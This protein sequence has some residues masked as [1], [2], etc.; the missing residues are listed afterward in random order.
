MVYI[1]VI[2]VLAIIIGIFCIDKK[3][4]NSVI[5]KVAKIENETLMWNNKDLKKK[6][7]EEKIFLSNFSNIQFQENGI[8]LEKLEKYHKVDK[9]LFLDYDKIMKVEKVYD[10][11]KY[12]LNNGV[13]TYDNYYLDIYYLE[14][15]MQNKERICIEKTKDVS[16]VDPA[17]KIKYNTYLSVLEEK[18]NEVSEN[19]LLV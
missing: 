3:Y 9:K 18:I 10:G 17:E 5:N 14:D 2:T 8:E 12:L 1:I 15:N 16:K 13:T 6:L 19:Q 11:N 4:E 7:K